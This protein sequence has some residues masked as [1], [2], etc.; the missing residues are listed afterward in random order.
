MRKSPLSARSSCGYSS[1]TVIAV[2]NPR[3]P[4]FTANSGMIA[5]VR[6]RARGRKQSSIAAQHDQQL[7]LPSA[8]W[9][10]ETGC[11]AR[12]RSRGAFV[13]SDCDAARASSHASSSGTSVAA[14]SLRGFEMRP[15]VLTLALGIEQKFPVAFGSANG[16]L[17]N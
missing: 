1:S 14:R 16:A 2:R 5:A 6:R 10:R 7:R 12:R 11:G 9:S 15:T 4:R 13:Q 17:E 8:T 3:L